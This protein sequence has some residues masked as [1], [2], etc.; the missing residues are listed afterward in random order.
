MQHSVGKLHDDVTRGSENFVFLSVSKSVGGGGR[1]SAN[2]L[3]GN[4]QRVNPHNSHIFTH[5]HNYLSC[6]CTCHRLIDT[7]YSH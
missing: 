3:A 1:A 5:A 4:D 7:H 2:F 6:S